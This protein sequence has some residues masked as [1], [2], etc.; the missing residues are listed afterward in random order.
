MQVV[1]LYSNVLISLVRSYAKVEH[2]RE[3]K[4]RLNHSRGSV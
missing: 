1:T 3:K 2:N 4:A